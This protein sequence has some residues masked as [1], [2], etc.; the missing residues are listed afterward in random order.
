MS[1]LD[2]DQ[3]RARLADGDWDADIETHLEQCAECAEWADRLA[4]VLELA[5]TLYQDAVDSEASGADR[6]ITMVRRPSA[7][8]LGWIAA[9][10]AVV[11]VV[12][13]FALAT[14]GSETQDRVAAATDAL[15]AAGEFRFVAE[16]DAS[17]A[18]PVNQLTPVDPGPVE[19][20]SLGRCNSS[21]EPP[22][23][24]NR[25]ELA[26]ALGTL[27]LTD[28]CSAL[29]LAS[30]EL[31]PALRE[32]ANQLQA[33]STAWAELAQMPDTPDSPTLDLE[34][35]SRELVREEAARRAAEIDAR[36]EQ[37]GSAARAAATST[38]QLADAETA[39]QPSDS[40][41]PIALQ[42]LQALSQLTQVQP[43]ALPAETVD[44]SLLST[45]TWSTDQAVASGTAD[46]TFGGSALS[47]VPMPDLA[48]DPVGA[49]SALLA[50]PATLIAVL[51]SAP[52]TDGDEITWLVP[53][54]LIE[55]PG[56]DQWEATAYLTETGTIDRLAL[57]TGSN[58]TIDVSVTITFAR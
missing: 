26:D 34:L 44:W 21:G 7:T 58:D 36:A 37:L 16:V 55:A 57:T 1:G 2:H 42:D 15:V 50:D 10:A 46:V 27:I 45:G 54:G 53:K 31:D 39:G 12:G 18:V 4:S 49:T 8:R 56:F 35:T 43:A 24:G 3:V 13:G 17:V 9:A 47:S 38:A 40:L 41:R 22:V 14:R 33:A 19:L 30:S 20:A 23:S 51:E 29:D 6:V 52:A 11:L 32:T 48:A 5:P 25:D 28:P